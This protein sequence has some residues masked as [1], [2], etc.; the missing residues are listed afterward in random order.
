MFSKK[1]RMERKMDELE[2]GKILSTIL[3]ENEWMQSRNEKKPNQKKAK[4][5]KWVEP[6]NK[7]KITTMSLDKLILWTFWNTELNEPTTTNWVCH[8]EIIFFA[9]R[10]QQQLQEKKMKN[11]KMV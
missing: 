2:W 3:T 6:L 8:L 10:Q 7:L 1:K 11:E 9:Q 5:A 4:Q